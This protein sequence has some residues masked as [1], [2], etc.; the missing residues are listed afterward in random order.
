[1]SEIQLSKFMKD[2]IELME[3][4][5]MSDK[6]IKNYIQRLY[7]LNGRKKF[8]SLS[9]LRNHQD[10]IKYMKD[11]LSVSTQK[12]YAGTISSVLKLKPSKSNE[13]LQEIYVSF[14]NDDDMEEYKK[15]VG[16]KSDKQQENWISQDE[17]MKIKNELSSEASKISKK[18]EIS[19]KEYEILLRN[20]ILSLYTNMPPRR[21]SDYALMKYQNGGDTKFNYYTDKNMM[22]FNNYKTSKTYGQQEIDVSKNKPLLKDMKMY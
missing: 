4:K 1:M 12:T 16:E 9:F 17:I 14:I 15:S 3:T 10:I 2:L 11:N 19:R 8:L 13:K 20:A 5:K 18:S 7:I 22:I 6:T 21:A